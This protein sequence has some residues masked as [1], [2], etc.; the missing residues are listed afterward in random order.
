MTE[1]SQ[2]PQF[3]DSQTTP[4]ISQILA[5]QRHSSVHL[6]TFGSR[7]TNNIRIIAQFHLSEDCTF[8]HWLYCTL[9]SQVW[10]LLQESRYVSN[11]T[12]S[13]HNKPVWSSLFELWCV[14]F[15]NVPSGVC[16]MCWLF[17]DT[18]IISQSLLHNRQLKDLWVDVMAPRLHTGWGVI[19]S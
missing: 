13:L 3:P 8:W 17:K 14:S 19:P 2:I 10:C 6:F 15:F 16:S 12:L 5:P 7:S 9:L 4:L 18:F 11:G 1:V